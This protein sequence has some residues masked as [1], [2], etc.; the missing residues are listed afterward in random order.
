[1]TEIQSDRRLYHLWR[2][3]TMQE[4]DAGKL[5]TVCKAH[6]RRAMH[7]LADVRYWGRSGHPAMAGGVSIGRL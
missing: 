2:T 5:N 4:N 1:M 7:H 6:K 3:G